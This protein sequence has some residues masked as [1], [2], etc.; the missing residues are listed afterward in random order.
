[1]EYKCIYCNYKTNKKY[2]YNRHLNAKHNYFYNE[3]KCFTPPYEK[4][5]PP[6]EKVHSPGEKVHPPGEKVHPPGEKVHPKFICKK[7]NKIYKSNRYLEVHEKN[8]KGIDDLTCPRCMISFTSK[9][10]KSNHIKRNSCKPRSIIH[11]RI[12]KENN[13]NIEYNIETQNNINK[14]INNNIYIN[15]YGNERL[16][17]INYDKMLDIFTKIY[18][19]AS[20]LTK[21]IHFNNDFPEN[22]N[23]QYENKTHALIKVKDDLVLKD[24]NLLAEELVKEKTDKVHK[25]AENNK[26]QICTT[27]ELEKYNEIVDLLFNYLILKEPREQY[28]IQVKNIKDMIITSKTRLTKYVDNS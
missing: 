19:S 17:Y 15:N 3:K 6:G 8:C 27:I 13:S 24:L 22:N 1:M 4:V 28:R 14:Q 23:I 26:E 16:D 10:G 18:N 20:L 11:A 21:E 25:F 5:H 2:N 9:Q 7:C 12:S